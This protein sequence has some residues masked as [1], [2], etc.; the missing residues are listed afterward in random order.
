MPGKIARDDRD[1][2][3]MFRLRPTRRAFV[4]GLAA[5]LAL[6]PGRSEALVAAPARFDLD[7]GG[8]A[9]SA[10]GIV[11][12]IEEGSRT[13]RAVVFPPGVYAYD[14]RHIALTGLADVT[15]RCEP[16]VVFRDRG[17]IVTGPDGEDFQLP[18]GFAFRDCPGA[19]DWTG[20][21]F[22]SLG[23]GLRGS[24]AGSFDAGNAH[25]RKA[26]LGFERC[27]GRVRLRQVG[28]RG[29]PGR[30]IAGA[31]RTRM[32][33]ALGLDPTPNQYASIS[34]NGAFFFAYD[35]P[36]IRREDCYLVAD[37]CS[38]EQVMFVGCSGGGR[39]E[40]SWSEGQNMASL[41][42][43][44]GCRDFDIGGVAG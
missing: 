28:H 25:L 29:N 43:V 5:L 26:V 7:P 41:G 6:R 19:I 24:S 36:D 23:A 35:C 2:P 10:A 16:G 38:R 9:D 3:G 39:N 32:L 8:R 40:R 20:G 34:G 17:R 31:D 11:Q 14:S 37:T 15:V 42:K 21:I 27:T 13:G 44:I 33:R 22:E 12:A 30:G 4:G 18:W 1:L